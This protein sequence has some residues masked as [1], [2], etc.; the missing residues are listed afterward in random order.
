MGDLSLRQRR[1]GVAIRHIYPGLARHAI[2]AV[3][4]EDSVDL[5]E[6][7]GKRPHVSRH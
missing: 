4:V 1:E 2:A 3:V 6:A 5:I 7:K